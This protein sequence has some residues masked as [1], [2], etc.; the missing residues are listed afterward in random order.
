MASTSTKPIGLP[1]HWR[2]GR[3]LAAFCALLLASLATLALR[4][5]GGTDRLDGWWLRARFT[6]REKLQGVP[7]PDPDIVF[8]DT[9]DK[10]VKQWEN[11]P[12]ILWLPHYAQAIQ[13]VTAGGASLIALDFLPDVS[14]QNL[15]SGNST[16]GKAAQDFLSSRNAAFSDAIS[17]APDIVMV[18]EVRRSTEGQAAGWITP[19]PELLYSAPNTD[20]THLDQNGLPDP[21]WLM[22]YPEF[23]QQSVVTSFRPFAVGPGK[24][25]TSFAARIVEHINHAHA[26]TKDGMWTIPGKVN[27]PLRPDGSVLINYRSFNQGPNQL[28]AGAV[29]AFAHYSL[30]DIAVPTATPD[31]RFHNKIVIFGS[32]YTIL[33]DLHFVPFLDGLTTR[34]ISG[35]QIQANLIRTLL[36]GDPIRE[37]SPNQTWLL[38]VM[39]GAIGMWAFFRLRWGPAALVCGL[40]TAL[41]IGAA[42]W[43]FAMS[44]LALPINL[45]LLGLV[46]AGGVMGIYRALGEERERQQVLGLWG[47]YQNPSQ[48]DY[49]L[50]HPEARGGE[51]QEWQVTV[52]FADLKNFT[53]TVEHLT[54]GD[55]IRALNR[56]LALMTDVIQDEFGGTVDKF[57][58]DGLMAVWGAPWQSEEARGGHAESAVRA[59]LELER[60]SEALTRAA[61]GPNDVTFGL[62]L[63]V[64]TGPVVVGWVGATR[65][66]LTIIGDTVNVTSRLQETAKEL[67]VEFL[68]SET[69]YTA[70]SDWARTGQEADVEIRGR[71][72]ALR[73]YEVLG[74]D[75]IETK[76]AGLA[77]DGNTVKN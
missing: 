71:N 72:Q 40:T 53:K 41:W 45:P 31:T 68:I 46:L 43:L 75:I 65:V 11:E 25:E 21:E 13:H 62:R 36:D 57:L 6:A 47:R 4:D 64:H 28:S 10:S 69:T 73:V 2:R 49:M 58:G 20:K 8:V 5:D 35:P 15:F 16:G 42:F 19:A 12:Q 32:S 54:P 23:L 52:L 44:S 56:Y 29:D 51:G 24:T 70:V 74:D 60:R 33:N 38:S 77:S 55:A 26:I 22:G 34:S 66:E 50:Q 39:L 30:V 7:K 48:V 18:K 67:R 3:L 37:P 17:K 61:T 27:V 63:S 76:P 9:D 14:F 59:C 1:A